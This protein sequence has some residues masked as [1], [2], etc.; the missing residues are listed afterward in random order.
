MKQFQEMKENF[1][2]AIVFFRLGDFYEMFGEDAKAASKVLQI[3]LTTRDKNKE[4]PVPMCGVPYFAAESYIAKLIKAG[5]KVAICEQVE[6]P[7][8][9][10]GVVRREVV[11]VITPGTFT[12]ENPKENN[13]IACF[14]PLGTKHGIAVADISTGEFLVL[15]T[16]NPLGDELDRFEPREVVYPEGLAGDI[17]CQGVLKN[18]FATPADEFLF[19]Y[20]EA[21]KSLLSHFKVSSL[22]AFGC[23]GFYAGITAAGALLNTLK[24]NQ[25][26]PLS[27]AKLTPL[28]EGS[29]MFMDAPTRKNLEL[30]QNLKDGGK[31]GSLLWALDETLTPMGGRFIRAALL[32]PLIDTEEIKRNHFSVKTLAE[33]YELLDSLRTALR[34]VQDLERLAARLN[35]GTANPRDLVALKSSLKQLPGIKKALIGS[36]DPLLVELGRSIGDFSSAVDAI[37][38]SIKE[39]P[40]LSLREGGIIKTGYHAEVDGLR[41]LCT[42]SKDY[43][44]RLEQ[45]EKKRTGIASLKVGFNRVFGYYIEV[46]KPNLSQVPEH[47]M[48]KQTLVNAERFITPELKEYETKALGAEERLKGLENAV[49][50]DIL[51]E[52]RAS[53]QALSATGVKIGK[54]DFLISLAVV[55]KRHN[56]VMPE[57]DETLALEIVN[58]RH[59]VIERLSLGERFI[60]NSLQMDT[61]EKTM[62]II[63]GPNMAG[64]STYMRQNALIVLMAQIGSFVP[65]E[66]ARIGL[67]DRI[68]TRIGASDFLTM[69]QSTFMVEMLETANIL[70]NASPRSLLILDEV[71]R[72][73]STFDGIS[74]AW[75]TAEHLAKKLGARTLFA[76]HF[77]ELTELALLLENVKNCNVAVKEWGEEILFLRRIEEG[78]SDKSYG[79]QVARLAGLPEELVERAKGVLANLEKQ[80]L[81]SKGMPRFMPELRTRGGQM[82][83][84]GG[85]EEPF[86]EEILSIPDEI[87]PE[88]AL[89]RIRELKKKAKPFRGD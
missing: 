73:T 75:A 72:G 43:I 12:P 71:G 67:V 59:P 40:P 31:E 61:E 46:T 70:H 18:F 4:E 30:L 86:I 15:E 36:G 54:L 41:A 78:P 38:Q 85:R 34:K 44:T 42:T 26:E 27:F 74:I 25:K 16:E 77:H 6:D 17:H 84:F 87:T 65:A 24:A 51:E 89:K 49:F 58:G 13:F 7:R 53:A 82:D 55:A 39:H 80:M 66:S 28:R 69:G 19:D 48:R 1:K 37:E 32:R 21:Y 5:Y 68:F 2:D 88:A 11:R 14:C 63:T 47:Y 23:E 60:P 81:N 57:V 10:K 83:L 20:S 29:H 62:L 35:M 33:D 45:E 79:I 8:D 64:K 52:V 3:A 22:D 9:A 76:T 56:Y 50:M